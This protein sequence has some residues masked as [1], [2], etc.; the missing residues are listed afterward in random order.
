[1]LVGPLFFLLSG[2]HSGVDDVEQSILCGKFRD[3]DVRVSAKR[4]EMA[5]EIEL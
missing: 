3:R 4:A 1:M 2:E 5:P